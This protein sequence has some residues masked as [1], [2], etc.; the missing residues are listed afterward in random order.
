MKQ[1]NT[2][3]RKQ[4]K[5]GNKQR[6]ATITLG[7]VYASRKGVDVFCVSVCVCANTKVLD[8]NDRI[9]VRK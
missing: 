6:K 7:G 3:K 8:Q 2:Q 1:Q 9:R 4:S 5:A